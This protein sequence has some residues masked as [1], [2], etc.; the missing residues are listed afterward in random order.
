MKAGSRFRIVSPGIVC[1]CHRAGTGGTT[2]WWGGIKRL[3]WRR[4]ICALDSCPGPPSSAGGNRNPRPGN[5]LSQGY[6]R[7]EAVPRA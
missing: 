6:C 2:T 5:Q 7:E 3:S 1:F 4:P